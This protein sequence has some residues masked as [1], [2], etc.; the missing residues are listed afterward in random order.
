MNNIAIKQGKEIL[1]QIN[2]R[3]FIR[4][5]DHTTV[6]RRSGYAGA[7]AS[8]SMSHSD[9]IMLARAAEVPYPLFLAQQS[10]V[11]EEI[12]KFEKQVFYGVEKTQLALATRG[13]VELA[14]IS[15][16]LKDLTRKQG[17]LK[18]HIATDNAYPNMYR[19][20]KK[21]IADRAEDLR[22][23]LGYDH[24]VVASQTKEQSFNYLRA[25]LAD[26]NVFVSM[27]MHNFCPQIIS[28]KLK[29]SGICIKDN[30]CPY[31]FIR[32]SDENSAV[33]PWGRR[34]FTLSLL[35]A[36]MCNGKFGA[37][38]MNGRSKDLISDDQYEL[39]EE[40]LMPQTLLSKVN[41]NNLDDVEA[42]ASTYS[43]SPSAMVMRLHRLGEIDKD[44]KDGYLDTLT[45]KFD[46]VISKKGGGK[47]P[48]VEKAISQYNSP[49]TVRIITDLVSSKNMSERD[50]RNLLYY[51]KGDS[52]D[53]GKIAEY[54]Q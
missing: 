32:A 37:V 30:K 40:F 49:K 12:T 19:R 38:S 21:S 2:E 45:E 3:I 4:L 52:F 22:T 18:K 14:D 5:F 46:R 17:E 35:L 15:L 28:P 48:V 34:L 44:Q 29:F 6:R 25:A 7:L 26:N 13:D 36:C 39:T 47:Q 23:K 31:I 10:F 27:Y 43:V 54:G 50:A 9:F 42:L 51:K 24:A 33:E 41:A 8:G 53:L 1:F 16:I 20:S 11:E